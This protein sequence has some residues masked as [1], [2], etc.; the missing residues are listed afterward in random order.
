[1][2]K[3]LAYIPTYVV[4]RFPRHVLHI[5]TWI[6]VR[7]VRYGCARDMFLLCKYYTIAEHIQICI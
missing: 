1:M 3:W 5:R 6:V 7:L 2:A 4:W